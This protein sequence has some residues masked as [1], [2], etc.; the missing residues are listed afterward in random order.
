MGGPL[1][2]NNSQWLGVSSFEKLHYKSC[3]KCPSSCLTIFHFQQ[4]TKGTKRSELLTFFLLFDNINL[5]CLKEQKGKTCRFGRGKNEQS[6]IHFALENF[7]KVTFD[8]VS[9]SSF[10]RYKGREEDAP[11]ALHRAEQYSLEWVLL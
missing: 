8:D 10:F 6:V 9:D 3:R 11:D 1:Q 5:S 4:K 7:C 2:S